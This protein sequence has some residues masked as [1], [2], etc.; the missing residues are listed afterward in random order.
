MTTY[1]FPEIR[2]RPDGSIDTGHYLAEGRTERSAAARDV[3][4]RL[5]APAADRP[6]P[7]RAGLFAALFRRAGTV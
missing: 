6:V 2:R 4:A 1:T 5:T 3:M 7:S